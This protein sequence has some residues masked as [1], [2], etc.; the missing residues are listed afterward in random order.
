MVEFFGSVSQNRDII[1]NYSE[2]IR[3]NPYHIISKYGVTTKTSFS[4]SLKSKKKLYF[5]PYERFKNEKSY[6]L[7]YIVTKLRDYIISRL[8]VLNERFRS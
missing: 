3:S 1:N 8:Q 4:K 2:K 5:F 6:I 7:F